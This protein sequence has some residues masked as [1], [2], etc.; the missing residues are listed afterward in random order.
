MKRIGKNESAVA[1]A[2]FTKDM[3]GVWNGASEMNGTMKNARYTVDI[4]PT[5]D[6]AVIATVLLIA[7]R[8][9]TSP[10]KNNIT[11]A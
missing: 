5:R 6:V 9:M 7:R 10:A 11:A 4:T 2:D 3:I 1:E 8:N